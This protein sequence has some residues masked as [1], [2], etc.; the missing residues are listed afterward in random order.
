MRIVER[1]SVG[2]LKA[3]DGTE[4]RLVMGPNVC[5]VVDGARG[6]KHQ[7]PDLLAG[8]LERAVSFLAHDAERMSAT[9]AVD[10][11]TEIVR[12]AK[13]GASDAP[14]THTGGFVF[15][16]YNA[17]AREVWRVGDC[18]YAIDGSVR[19]NPIEA[20]AVGAQQRAL[21]IRSRLARGESAAEIMADPAYRMLLVAHLDAQLHFANRADEPYG[22]G[23]VNG[24]AVPE[25]FVQIES[26]AH[27]ASEVVITS[28]SYPR[29][30]NTLAEAEGE[31]ARLLTLDPMCIGQNLGPKGM[32]PSMTTYD[33]RTY[34]RIDV[35]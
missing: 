33:D 27:S 3:S 2:K 9:R 28:D 15:C 32:E 1:F 30:A 16:V 10:R 21:M 7:N 12:E 29:P 19:S 20:E 5:G 31:L 8:I 24:A 13:K 22:F 14:L 11:L 23:V 4:D 17:R 25:C 34:I 26:V 35:R 18:A 6:P